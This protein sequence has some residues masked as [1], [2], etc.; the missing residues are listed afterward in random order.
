MLNSIACCS[1]IRIDQWI[2]GIGEVGYF[3]SKATVFSPNDG[4]P[5]CVMYT[6]LF[7]CKKCLKC[8]YLPL[9]G[10]QILAFAKPMNLI[11]SSKKTFDT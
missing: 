10:N 9:E 8:V 1:G 6:V 7:V 2:L 3:S 4:V 5:C 11:N